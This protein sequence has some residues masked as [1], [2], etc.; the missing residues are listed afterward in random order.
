MREHEHRLRA[1]AAEKAPA[2]PRSTA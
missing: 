1:S 2:A